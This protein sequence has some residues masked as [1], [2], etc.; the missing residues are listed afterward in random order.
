MISTK[1]SI[2]TLLE[3]NRDCA[4]S[5]SD[6]A[7]RLNISRSAV[8][9]GVEELRREGYEI[10]AVT[11]RGYSLSRHSDILSAEG[12]LNYL[13]CPFITRDKIHVYKSIGSTNQEAKK[14]A[15]AGADQGTLVMAEGQTEGRGRMGRSFFSPEG[16]GI[17][18]SLI[19]RPRDSDFEAMSATAAA[20]SAVCRALS[21]VLGIKA[22]IKWVNDIF[23]DDLKVCGILAEA[24][25]DFQTHSIES[26]II[27]IGINVLTKPE[28]FP[29]GIRGI[30]GSLLKTPAPVSRN[31]IAAAVLDSLWDL[32]FNTD[33]ETMIEEYRSRSFLPGRPI[34]VHR[35]NEVYNAKALDIDNKGGLIIEKYDGSVETLRSGEV[36]VRPVT[37]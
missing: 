36:S 29:E 9:K 30:A 20:A 3:D 35:G 26:L 18:M 6:I 2:L 22:R 28:A 25:S 5:G 31:Q 8:W 12:L 13:C 15:V 19:L 16:T 33:T 10:S 32:I 37:Y 17:Y 1:S 21:E 27:G 11:N 7:K 23:V 24:V 14:L 4:L 34:T